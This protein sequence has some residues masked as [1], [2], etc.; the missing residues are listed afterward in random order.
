[1]PTGYTA[2]IAD[3]ITF[4]DFAMNCARAMGALVMMRDEPTGA[5]IP[6][7]FEPSDYHVKAIAKA[8]ESLLLLEAMSAAE[9]T[10]KA[11]LAFTEETE[12]RNS[13]MQKNDDLRKKYT[14]MLQQVQAWEPP[15]QDH[16]GFKAFMVE[17]INS[18]IDFDCN[19]S[20]YMERNPI[21]L[22]GDEWLECETAKAKKDLDYHTAE[23][24]KEI[25]RT[26]AR[27][28]W[29]KELRDSLKGG[30]RT[31]I[32]QRCR[33]ERTPFDVRR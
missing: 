23:N 3:D 21:L 19:N 7:R 1:M 31:Q 17:Q 18:S 9:A 13:A 8:K 4:N 12:Y 24:E 16:N 6:E 10:E 25:E 15:T 2:A 20:Y 11:K 32:N 28:R 29:V 27:N 26:E 14:S 30:G 5:Q 33:L 22:S